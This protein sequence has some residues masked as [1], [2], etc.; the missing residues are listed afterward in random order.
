MKYIKGVICLLI[1]IIGIWLGFIIKNFPFIKWNKEVKIYEVFQIAGTLFIGLVIPFFIK[2]WI[3]DGRAMKSLFVEEVKEI[4][5]EIKKIR[6]SLNAFYKKETIDG[7]DK[8]F[9]IY[10]LNQIEN[11][12]STL[13]TKL[14]EHYGDVVTRDYNICVDAYNALSDSLTGEDF[15]AD[16]FKTIDLQFLSDNDLRLNI[17]VSEIRS[18]AIKLQKY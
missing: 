5:V 8:N 12:L 1:L 4:V 7:N 14:T 3:E 15:M 10:L 6:E 2:K 17:L 13:G 16:N 11:L 9:I 18:L